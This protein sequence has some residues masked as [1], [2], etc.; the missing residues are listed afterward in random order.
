M[1]SATTLYRAFTPRWAAEPLSGAGAALSG[2]RFNRYDVPALYLSL[3][4]ATAVAEYQQAAPFVPP[5][6][7]VTYLATLPAL[8]DVRLLDAEWDELWIDWDDDWRALLVSGIEPPSWVL[9][10]MARFAG[11]A[12]IIFP[13]AAAAGGVNL[14]LFMDSVTAADVLMIQDDGRLPRDGSSWE[15]NKG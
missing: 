11:Y 3:E 15:S 2:G 8:V 9:G 12:G 7:M 1:A 5:F 14:A 4:L 6:T 13:S 10:D